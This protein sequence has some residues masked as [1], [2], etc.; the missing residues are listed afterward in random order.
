M[1]SRKTD[2]VVT[3]CMLYPYYCPNIP[4]HLHVIFY[5][6]ASFLLTLVHVLFE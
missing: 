4:I 2:V 3:T 5:F 6:N 1:N